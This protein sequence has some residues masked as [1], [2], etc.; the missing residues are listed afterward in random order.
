[1][2]PLAY[3]MFGPCIELLIVPVKLSSL[4]IILCPALKGLPSL[5]HNEIRDLTARLLTEVCHQ[6]QMEPVSDP[7]PF[8]LSTANTQ[9]A[10]RW[11]LL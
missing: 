11:T 4:W 8:S 3:V 9:E 7:G 2:L 1:M 6:V 5:H 10:S